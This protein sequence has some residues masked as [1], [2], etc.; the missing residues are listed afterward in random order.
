MLLGIHEGFVDL[1][2]L[3]VEGKTVF[4]LWVELQALADLLQGVSRVT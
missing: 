3:L 1:F 2:D 4:V